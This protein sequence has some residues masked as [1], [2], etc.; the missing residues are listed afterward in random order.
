MAQIKIYGV[1]EHLYRVKAELSEIIHSCV[2]DALQ[3]PPD[4]RAHRF[5][6]LAADD[7]YYPA[8]RTE[9]YTIIEISM[10]EGRSVEAKKRLINLLFERITT[11]L[12]MS[13]QD[14]EITIFETPRHNW[15]IRGVPGDELKLNYK[16]EV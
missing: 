12:R 6:P 7:F 5:L 3:Y 16:V 14:I 4:K 9:Q 11:Q 15:G 10:F 2:M 8:G 1:K 13:A